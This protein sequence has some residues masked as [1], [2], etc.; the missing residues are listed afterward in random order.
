MPQTPRCEVPTDSA[1]E[2]S[3]QGGKK[4]DQKPRADFYG[5]LRKLLGE[6]RYQR[7]SIEEGGVDIILRGEGPS[8]SIQIRVFLSDGTIQSFDIFE[9][10][11]VGKRSAPRVVDLIREIEE[12][13]SE[14]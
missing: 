14:R 10:R 13:L 6:R 11:Q 1:G 12:A 8:A 5:R 3:S 2:M 9:D 4:E 7:V